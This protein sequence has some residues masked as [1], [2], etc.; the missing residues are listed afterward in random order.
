MPLNIHIKCISVIIGNTMLSITGI[1]LRHL[2]VEW[3]NKK[4]CQYQIHWH[5][6]SLLVNYLCTD[7]NS[8]Y[9]YYYY[10][11]KRVKI[12]IIITFI[13]IKILFFIGYIL[14]P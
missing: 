10:Y 5:R 14:R 13:I 12:I 3:N 4:S 2:S 11:K 8:N 7:K 1:L 6:L 9:N